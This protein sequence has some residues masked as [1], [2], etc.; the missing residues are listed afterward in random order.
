MTQMNAETAKSDND[1]LKESLTALFI[2]GHRRASSL[3]CVLLFGIAT[4]SQT[5][6]SSRGIE[7]LSVS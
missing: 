2:C 5:D 7:R 6:P 1:L 3:I 4:I